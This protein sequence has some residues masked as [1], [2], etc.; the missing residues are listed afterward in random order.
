MKIFNTQSK[1]AMTLVETL[2]VIAILGIILFIT[3]PHLTQ[4]KSSSDLAAA[5]AK[6]AQLNAA[7]DAY[8]SLIGITAAQNNWGTPA[9]DAARFTKIKPLIRPTTTATNLTDFTV[10]GYTFAFDTQIAVP[11]HLT[12]TSTNTEL[13]Y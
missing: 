5:K 2:A 12:D 1:T 7:K 8:I 11:V 6:A 3:L 9:T 10:P 4:S 13:A